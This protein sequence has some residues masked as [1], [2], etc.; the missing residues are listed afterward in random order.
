MARP[1]SRPP[2]PP[3]TRPPSGTTPSACRP[4]SQDPLGGIS[5]YLYDTNGNLISYTDAAGDTYQ[6][7]Y[8]QNG[9]LTQTVNPL[10]QTVQHDLRPAQQPDL[11]HRRRRQ[12]DP[13]Q[14]QL[15]RQPAQHRLPR[16]HPAVVHLRSARQP[17]RDHR[18]KRRPGQLSVQRPGPGRRRRSFADGTSQTFTYDA[19]GN[20]LTA[21]TYRLRR[22]AHRHDHLTYNAANE[23]TSIIYPNGQSLDFTY[24]A[25]G[26]R[27]R[28]SIRDGFT[29][30][31]SYDALGRLSELTDGSGNLIVQYTYNNLGELARKAN[32]NGTYTTYAYD[33]AAT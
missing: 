13:V 6:Y 10:G 32:G 17:D 11:D 23:L 8:D 18:A 4:A 12:H 22:H 7:S 28:A 3:A 5:T 24:N 25:Q 16:R 29:I 15:R 20:L 30:N 9:N 14:L 21:E 1:R 33:A 31:Y 27:T 26:Q 19:H 2:T